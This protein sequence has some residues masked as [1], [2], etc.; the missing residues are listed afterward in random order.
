MKTKILKTLREGGRLTRLAL[1]FALVASGA[2]LAVTNS[3][4][5]HAA[6]ANQVQIDNIAIQYD[7]DEGNIE[8]WSYQRIDVDWSIPGEAETPVTLTIDLPDGFYGNPET[9]PVNGP[10]GPAGECVVTRTQVTCTIDDAFIEANPHGVSGD[11][12]FEARTENDNRQNVKQTIDIGGFENEVVVTPSRNWCTEDCEFGQFWD[13]KWGSYNTATDEI[14]F[15]VQVKGGNTGIA[16]GNTVTVTDLLDEDSYEL[17]TDGEYPR[18]REA[19]LLQY[20]RWGNEVVGGWQTYPTSDVVWSNGDLTATFES[21]E[22]RGADWNNHDEIEPSVPGSQRGTDGSFYQVQWKVKA[23]TGGDLQDNGDRVFRNAAEWDI[24][25]EESGNVNGS[26]TRYNRGGNVVGTNYGKFQ[27]T[28]ELTGDTTLTPAFTVNYTVTEPGQDPAEKSFTVH[29]GETFTSQEFFRGSVVELTEV[30]P[31]DP[32]NVTWADPVFLDADGNPADT[33]TFT[34]DGNGKLGAIT[35]IRL[36]NEATLQKGNFSAQKN[37]VNEDGVPLAD[38]LEFALDYSYPADAEKGFAAG[39]GTLT[40]PISGESVTSDAL[41]IGAVLTLSEP[42]LPN[43]PGSTWGEPVIDPATLTIGDSNDPV[44]VSVTNTITQDVGGFSITK[45]VTGEGTELVP[46][47]AVFT[48]TYDYDAINGFP[49]GSG[50]IEFGAGETETVDGIPAGATVTL[51]ELSL[52]DPT[53]GTWGE[54]EFS[55][56]SFTIVKDTV[57]DIDLD[58]PISWNDG[59]FSVLKA[60]TGDGADLVDEDALFTVDYTYTLPE[61][62]GADPA[63]GTGTLTV[64]NDGQAVVSDSLPY[65]TEVTLDEAA[66]TAV[67]GGTWLGYEFDNPTLTIGDETTFEVVLTN[68]IERD[69]GGFSVTKAVEGTGSDLIS[70]NEEFTVA[71]SYPAGEWYEAGE[72]TLTVTK[73]GT[74]AVDG[75]PASAVVTLEE[76]LPADP[77][78]GTWVSAT[79][80]EG[81]IALI[82]KNETAE[83]SLVNE[84]ELGTGGLSIQKLI[85]GTGKDLVADGTAFVVHYTYDSGIGFEA[86]D[87]SIEVIADGSEAVVDG[88]PAGAVV[89][90]TEQE[91]VAVGGATWTAAEFSSDTVTIGKSEV[92]D[93]ILTNTIDKDAVS[94]GLATT[95]SSGTG[96]GTGVAVLMVLG[97]AAALYFTRRRNALK[98]C[99]DE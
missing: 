47:D 19:G 25:G 90:L 69:L 98:V 38:D 18:V 40:L 24:Y 46:E 52:D 64:A 71:Y 82:N 43:V 87:G 94:S 5:A 78:N 1:A 13:S 4:P 10:D 85:T 33:L 73:G 99:G 62:L 81:N 9:F 44:M 14:I 3:T 28:K 7:D 89:Q 30:K 21:R 16:P 76:A 31:T 42:N 6:E 96:L 26:A 68:E 75:L 37:V 91:P 12:F 29:S 97:G 93:I 15:T 67:A 17:V 79:F 45:A 63:T 59:A 80:P 35:E 66:P 56:S 8:D 95:G 51:T 72:G 48:V 50:Q 86:G 49:A 88:L 61:A 77:E 58:N 23:L 60:V 74:T 53:G 84:V 20:D 32:A 22:G 34:A 11:F 2:G 41:P 70:A 54:P 27:V 55:E 39:S 92:V 65:G 83:V 36:V 57:V